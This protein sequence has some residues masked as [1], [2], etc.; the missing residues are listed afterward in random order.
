MRPIALLTLI[1]LFA[2]PA[3]AQEST[4]PALQE[5]ALTGIA[6]QCAEQEAGTLC[7]GGA[8]VSPVYR[9]RVETAPSFDTP[10]DAI[11]ISNI[12]WLSISS[13]DRTWGAVRALFPVYPSDGL[14]SRDSALLAFGN[15][16][17]FLPTPMT[18]PPALA[19]INVKA[20]QGANLRASPSTDANVVALLAVSRPLKALGR[21]R[22]GDWLLVYATPELRG[23]ISESVVSAPLADLPALSADAD[24]E[25]LWLPWHQF[26]FL[27]GMQDAPCEDAPE[28][29][30]LLQAVKFI[31]PRHFVI[32]GARLMLSGTAWLQA[33]ASSGMLI[34]IIDGR[35]QVAS[36]GGEVAVRS[37]HFTHIALERNEYGALTPSAPPSESEAY[38]YHELIGLPVHAL[39]YETRVGLDVYTVVDP[40][41]AGGGRPL[42]ALAAVAPCRFSA[43]LSGANIRAR[44]DPESPIIAVM[45]YRESAEP[46][47]R[48]IGADSLPWWKLADRVWV[49]VDATVAGG[50][51]NEI[52]LIRPE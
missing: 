10:G 25:A 35:A 18:P 9:E 52:P 38:A 51:C 14:V 44:P 43:V 28:S 50:N 40:A 45:A 2:A 32:N 29:G 27:S 33:Q 12:D 6:Q 11:A 48:G 26:D 34:H 49:R 15:V 23:W 20:S 3:A 1:A 16:A 36:A 24:S 30:I 7:F 4:C 42:E 17:L 41:P 19:D 22:G 21:L 8:T 31:A 46:I 13:E 37:G 47:A 39:P 5:L